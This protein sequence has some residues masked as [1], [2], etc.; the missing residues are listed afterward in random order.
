MQLA[1]GH[2]V[3]KRILPSKHST[4]SVALL[5]FVFAG[6]TEARSQQPLY[7]R[8]EAIQG[9]PPRT[10]SPGASALVEPQFRVADE[11]GGPEETERFE[12]YNRPFRELA[13]AGAV[14]EPAAVT[15]LEDGV[16]R[17]IFDYLP[18]MTKNFAAGDQ[19]WTPPDPHCAAGPN[20]VVTIVNRRINVFTKDGANIYQSSLY[21]FFDPND[22]TLNPYDSKVIY[23]E[24]T[25]RFF[26]LSIA[27]S[28]KCSARSYCYLAVSKS[29]DPSDPNNWWRYTIE[30]HPSLD[31]E[32]IDYP[33]LG[34]GPRAVYVTFIYPW[35]GGHFNSLYVLDKSR[36]INGLTYAGWLFVDT[37]DETGG[38]PG[39]IRATVTFGAPSG[40]DAFLLAFG[41]VDGVEMAT[42]WQVALPASF[43]TDP[44]TLDRRS[45]TLPVPAGLVLAEQAGG[46]GLIVTWNVGAPPL[47]AVYQNGRVWS[48]THFGAGITPERTIVRYYAFNV[49][50][51]P[52][53]SL[54]D[55]QVMWDGSSYYYWP[56]IA[57]NHHGDMALVFS[58]SST[59]E[60]AGSRWTVLPAEESA[61]YP[62]QYLAAGQAYYGDPVNDPFHGI[63]NGGANNGSDCDVRNG[64]GD[65]PGGTC[66]LTPPQ[67][68]WGD[69]AGAAVDPV[70]HGFW[71]FH[72][73][74]VARPDGTG[75]WSV[76]LGYIPRA[77]F[78]DQAY[79]GSETGTRI[80]P[81]N[82]VTEGHASA[83]PGDDLVIR[84][85]FYSESVT[86]NK[87]VNILPD[88]G[89]VVIVGQ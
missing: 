20:H 61:L 49:S 37:V 82:T 51:W 3:K 41:A 4:W 78:V 70:S 11:E 56:G 14:P 87:A 46:P 72:E 57:V 31:G 27:I 43:P 12:F 68:R 60:Y 89:P 80:H 54:A 79:G 28:A 1:G 35:C 29:S 69:Y 59:S 52:T 74:A 23:D 18:R 64:N 21:G 5:G 26:A 38:S 86:L 73:C 58:R 71:L 19:S 77:V 39:V 63:C 24:D 62:S 66:P 85:G 84:S 88:G 75:M 6:L 42:L 65:C 10:W 34:V 15:D 16:P 83:L 17:S 45:V 7:G 48:S 25:Q 36:L 53:V 47:E 13:A 22:L 55:T 8:L 50:T 9:T 40:A 81:W 67:Y 2:A 33:S 30:D 32:G 44:P 76:R